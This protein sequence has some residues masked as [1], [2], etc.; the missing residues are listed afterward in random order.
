MKPVTFTEK[1]RKELGR[2]LLAYRE[3]EGMSL[4]KAVAY[5]NSVVEL[6]KRFSK[7]ALNDIE[8]GIVK[9]I[10]PKTL[11]LLSQAGYG[12]MGFTEM[13]DILTE[14]RLVLCEQSVTY[15]VNKEAIAV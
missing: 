7:S 13:V 14:R 3:S 10:K 12:G 9:E 11:M 6:E 15:C 8:N 5:I 4:D 2:R 1:G